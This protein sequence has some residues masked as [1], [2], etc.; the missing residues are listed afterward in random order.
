MSVRTLCFPLRGN[1][2]QEVLLG[3]KKIGFGA[4][5][6]NGFGGKVERGET[7][8]QAALLELQEECGLI[9][10]GSDLD[11]AGQVTFIFPAR[12]D[13]NQTV[14]VFRLA[15]WQGEPGESKEMRPAWFKIDALPLDK[16]WQDDSYWL[17]PVLHGGQVH[18]RFVFNDDNET[19]KEAVEEG[20]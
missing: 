2:P 15:K 17:A 18:M 5:K 16:M 7:I 14:H 6:F 9:G 8:S 19:V 10:K 3:F 20:M 4:G 11:Y 12:E 13:W 1:P